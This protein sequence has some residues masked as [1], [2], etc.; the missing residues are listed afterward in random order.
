MAAWHTLMH[1]DIKKEILNN[2]TVW[3]TMAVWHYVSMVSY[4]SMAVW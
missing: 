1:Y 2:T 4:D 3:L